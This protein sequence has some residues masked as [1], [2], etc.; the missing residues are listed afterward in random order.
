VDRIVYAESEEAIL[1]VPQEGEDIGAMITEKNWG[2]SIYSTGGN[3]GKSYMYGYGT[4]GE[5]DDYEGYGQGYSG[6]G[7]QRK[8][9]KTKKKDWEWDTVNRKWTW[10]D[11]EDSDRDIADM[12]RD[13]PPCE[14][15]S[16]EEERAAIE[17]TVDNRC[18][19]AVLKEMA[20]EGGL[21][22]EAG[23][24]FYVKGLPKRVLIPYDQTVDKNWVS[25]KLAMAGIVKDAQDVG[26]KVSIVGWFPPISLMKKVK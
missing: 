1:C 17:K 14:V 24:V 8:N 5:W 11:V 6:Y 20:D 18:R 23:A 15:G 4:G 12:D 2:G 7:L 9:K 25:F 16:V 21:V 22:Q 3:V 10:Q 13:T 19:K 26:V